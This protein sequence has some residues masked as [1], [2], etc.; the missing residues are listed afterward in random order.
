MMLLILAGL[1]SVTDSVVIS[2]DVYA[3]IV[4]FVMPV[5]SAM[6]PFLYT[7]NNYTIKDL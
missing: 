6:N 7:Y 5:N 2:G 1:L 3:W 4:V